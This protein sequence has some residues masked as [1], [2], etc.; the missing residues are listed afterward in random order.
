[1]EKSRQRISRRLPLNAKEEV[2]I[3]RLGAGREGQDMIAPA[4]HDL[5]LS[6]ALLG[7]KTGELERTAAARVYEG[8]SPSCSIG[9]SKWA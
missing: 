9:S 4:R 5:P 3:S 7:Q 8:S 2:I 6:L 1:M